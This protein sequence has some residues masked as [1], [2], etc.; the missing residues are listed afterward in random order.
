MV[1]R[2]TVRH[3]SVGFLGIFVSQL[4]SIS[5]LLTLRPFSAPQHETKG[6]NKCPCILWTQ[7]RESFITHASINVTITSSQSA[8]IRQTNCQY[9]QHAM[10]FPLVLLA[11][12]NNYVHY[13]TGNYLNISMWRF[14]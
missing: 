7:I 3:V 6:H 4:H 11:G 8:R 1:A 2:L 5:V 12:I 13:S 10:E 14:E 9:G